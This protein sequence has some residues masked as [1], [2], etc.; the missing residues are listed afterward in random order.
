MLCKR[1]GKNAGVVV[2]FVSDFRFIL[3]LTSS[4]IYD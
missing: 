1:N 4:V 3:I 2:I